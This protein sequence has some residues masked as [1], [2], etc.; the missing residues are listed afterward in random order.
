MRNTTLGT[1]TPSS[2]PVQWNFADILF[3]RDVTILAE[4]G[5]GT[6]FLSVS[7]TFELNLGESKM[8]T[9]K[10]EGSMASHCGP[11]PLAALV[12]G[13][14]KWEGKDAGLEVILN[15]LTFKW[16]SSHHISNIFR[17]VPSL[18]DTL[19]EAWCS[20]EMMYTLLLAVVVLFGLSRIVQE[21]VRIA[22]RPKGTRDLPGPK[23]TLLLITD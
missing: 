15:P 6:V 7:F 19:S 3:G 13:G 8:K 14:V 21:S 16:L 22:R 12:P 1:V 10:R 11:T 4:P 9:P 17:K 2:K 23:G 5:S 18:L 20:Y